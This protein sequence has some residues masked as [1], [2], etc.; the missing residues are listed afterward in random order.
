ML[1]ASRLTEPQ[2]SSNFE[3][4]THAEKL[5]NVLGQKKNELINHHKHWVVPS[6]KQ[7][8]L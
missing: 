7:V 3:D 8:M 1:A 5:K 4:M 2:A 6:S